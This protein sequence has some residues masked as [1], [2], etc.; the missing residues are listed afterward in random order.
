VGRQKG[1]GRKTR[2]DRWVW[3]G[4]RYAEQSQGGQPREHILGY[5]CLHSAMVTE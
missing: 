3:E 1:D 4:I 5:I 2:N